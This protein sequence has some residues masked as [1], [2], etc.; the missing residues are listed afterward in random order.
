MQESNIT[1][2][3]L[4]ISYKTFRHGDA[5]ADEVVLVLHGWGRGSDTWIETG[6]LLAQ[7]GFL[8]IIPDLPGFGKSAVPRTPWTV[9]DYLK[10]VENF[11]AELRL[12]KFN[13]IGHSFGGGLGAMF[14]AKNP[15]KIN[16]LVLCDSAIIRKERL[17]LRQIVAKG[18][19]KSGKFVL[20]L[21]FAGGIVPLA[22]RAIYKIAGVHDYQTANPVMK[23]TFKNIL[24][25]DL[26]GHAT[27]IK[28]PT[29]IIWGRDDKSTPV[30]DAAVLNK[31][32]AGSTVAF[33]EGAGH[34]S[35]KTHPQE[36][37][38]IIDDF[39]KS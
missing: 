18:I 13:V 1:M 7:K 8:V 2:N 6:E 9:N 29:M 36:L 22:Q 14:A 33:I 16:K 10:F 35:H 32:I 23:E 26:I 37:A 31:I 3:G 25:E 30:E 11:A 20:A 5:S 34:N 24:R 12:D 27:K 38:R 4:K 39:L 19:V 17:S 21:P 15:Q 28:V